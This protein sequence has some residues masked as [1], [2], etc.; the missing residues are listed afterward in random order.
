LPDGGPVAANPPAGQANNYVDTPAVYG[1]STYMVQ[2][3]DTL[4]SISARYGTTVEAFMYANNMT[5][6]MIY[7]GQVLNIPSDDGSAYAAPPADY[8]QAPPANNNYNNGYHTVAMGD[9]LFSIAQWYN[10]SVE[11]IAS[12]NGLSYPYV[13]YEGQNLVIPA[14][15][16]APPADPGYYQQP[17]TYPQAPADGSYPQQT[18]PAPSGIAGTHTVSPGETL[19]SIAQRYGTTAQAISMANGIANPNQIYV[20]QV[21]Y[22]P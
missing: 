9:T 4:F 15:G 2:T 13:I 7:E 1:G 22:L 10:T 18:Y 11:A 17:Q 5:T 21:L 6:D 19:F 12:A 8:N 16:A 3:G 20:G 14:Y